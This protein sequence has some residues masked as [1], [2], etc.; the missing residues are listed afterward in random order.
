MGCSQQVMIN[1]NVLAPSTARS[2]VLQGA[3]LGQ[4]LFLLYINDLPA[5]VKQPPDCSLNTAFC[6]GGLSQRKT[7]TLCKKV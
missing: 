2:G 7:R 1:I 6:T 3:V 4:Q 5:A